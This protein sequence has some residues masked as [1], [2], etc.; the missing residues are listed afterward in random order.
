MAN[1][2]SAVKRVETNQKKAAQNKSAYSEMQT[3]I[4]KFK[5]LIMSNKAADAEKALPSVISVIDSTATAGVI[6]K[7]AAA[8]R[9]SVLSKMLNDLK[10]GKLV[11][12]KKIDNK[13][14]AAMKAAAAKAEKDKVKAEAA[15]K[16]EALKSKRA[17]KPARPVKEDRKLKKA[18]A[19]TEEVRIEKEEKP[20]KAEKPAKEEKPVK[21]KKAKKA[22]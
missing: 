20:A 19:E 22:E 21:E 17:E 13:E 7:N 12:V 5:A 10:T 14:R 6:H 1:I 2:K 9:V 3:A 15:L 4:K 18:A 16:S 8:R 11:I